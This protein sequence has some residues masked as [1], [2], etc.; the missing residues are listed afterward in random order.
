MIGP[1]SR[2]DSPTTEQ[3]SGAVHIRDIIPGVVDDI[4][5]RVIAVEL[6]RATISAGQ[7]AIEAFRHANAARQHLNL[8]WKDLV[9][10]DV[11]FEA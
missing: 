9:A 5:R 10:A 4:F 3:F 1:P 7:E 2:N 6:E 11:H 8:S